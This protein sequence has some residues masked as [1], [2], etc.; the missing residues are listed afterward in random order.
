M[1]LRSELA[2]KQAFLENPSNDFVL[3]DPTITEAQKEKLRRL[4]KLVET[5]KADN[6]QTLISPHNRKWRFSL[7]ENANGT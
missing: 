1:S 5:I 7:T 4:E 6:E 3:G 2:E